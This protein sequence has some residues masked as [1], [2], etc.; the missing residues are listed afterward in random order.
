MKK[1]LRLAV[2]I[3]VLLSLLLGNAITVTASPFPYNSS[4]RLNTITSWRTIAS[5]S[6]RNNTGIN[7]NVLI[8]NNNVGTVGLGI[9]RSDVRMLD[10]NGRV[11]W[12]G[13]GALAGADNRV[14]WCGPNVYTVQ[15][16]TQSGRGTAFAQ[17]R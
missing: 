2:A 5:V 3:V 13:R 8:Q 4:R 1:V 6:T 14:F 10:R 16:R 9:A 11:V 12:E 7:R 15:I 17:P